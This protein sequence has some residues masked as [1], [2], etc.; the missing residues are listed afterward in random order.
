MTT[1]TRIRCGSHGWLDSLA[2]GMAAICAVHCL[3]TPLLMI[4][5]P[6][7][8]STFWAQRD[9]HLWM[10]L[11]VLP[12]TATAV[13]LG[14]RKHK[15]KVVVILS[16]VGLSVLTLVAFHEAFAETGVLAGNEAAC[17]H[18]VTSETSRLLT[19]SVVLNLLGS[20]FLSSA[21][22]RNYWL[23]RKAACTHD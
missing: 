3:V 9:F 20:V 11:L 7:V 5:I 4:S 19:G 1:L 17:S 16:I 18:C 12:T 22:A 2:V 15:D 14:C 21:H 23:C 6:V 8:A 13:F 10:V